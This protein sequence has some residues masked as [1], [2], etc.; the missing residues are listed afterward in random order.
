VAPPAHNWITLNKA[1]PGQRYADLD[2][3]TPANVGPLTAVCEIQ[4][5]EPN[6]FSTGPLKEGRCTSTSPR[7]VRALLISESTSCPGSS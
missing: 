4:L 3:I 5:N 1:Y 7:Q 2:R 6:L